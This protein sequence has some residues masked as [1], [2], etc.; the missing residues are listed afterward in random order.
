MASVIAGIREEIAEIEAPDL[1]GIQTLIDQ[2]IQDATNAITGNSGGKV[3]LN[4]PLH[5]QELL[6]LTD[7]NSSI[8]TA[9]RLW[10]WN[11]GG[12]GFSANGYNG[13]FSTAITADGKIVAD[14]ITAGTMTANVIKAGIFSDVAGKFSVNMTTGAAFLSGA[15]ITGGS[16]NITNGSTQTVI[17]AYGLTT[18][19]AVLYQPQC[20]ERGHV[21]D[22]QLRQP[23]RLQPYILRGKQP[24]HAARRVVYLIPNQQHGARLL[25]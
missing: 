13:P 17:D 20:N 2:A 16:I 1:S 15:T 14:F 22:G 10:R 3:I 11:A 4:P 5:P 6:V 8:Q 19:Y 25:P 9:V 23:E 21:H 12:L 7:A 24:P 18:S